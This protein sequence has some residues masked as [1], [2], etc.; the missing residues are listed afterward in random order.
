MLCHLFRKKELLRG[1]SDFEF[2]QLSKVHSSIPHL[3]LRALLPKA[4]KASESQD[5]PQTLL[6]VRSNGKQAPSPR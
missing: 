2:S 4:P 6:T 1:P 5:H 3:K